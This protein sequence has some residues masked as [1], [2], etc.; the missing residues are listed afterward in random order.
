MLRTF[1]EFLQHNILV[2]VFFHLIHCL[3]SQKVSRCIFK[4]ERKTIPSGIILS[5][6]TLTSTFPLRVELYRFILIKVI[7]S[8]FIFV[9]YIGLR[10]NVFKTL[11]RAVIEPVC[12]CSSNLPV[13]KTSGK[14]LSGV[15]SGDIILLKQVSLFYF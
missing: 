5:N 3:V 10:F 12:Q 2:Q 13:V 7:F 11:D 6:L 4:T 14:F 8:H 9:K 1:F 15:S